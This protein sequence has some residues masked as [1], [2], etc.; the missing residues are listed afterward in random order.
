MHA[1]S[2]SPVQLFGTSQTVALQASLSVG[3]SKQEYCS[4]LPFS[5]LGDLPNPGIETVSPVSPALQVGSW[6]LS[7]LGS[8]LLHWSHVQSLYRYTYICKCICAKSLHCVRLCDSMDCSPLGSSVHGIF[9]VRI[10]EWVSISYV[11]LYWN[12]QPHFTYW[13]WLVSDLEISEVHCCCS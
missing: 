4:G 2:L 10:V 6:P 5:P 9:P 7:H 3:F 11:T 8:P 13:Q 12:I 1:P